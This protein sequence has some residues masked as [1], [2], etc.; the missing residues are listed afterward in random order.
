MQTVIGIDEAGRGPVLGPLVIGIVVWNQEA[1][2]GTVKISDSKKLTKRQ[3]DRARKFI[4]S[5]CQTTILAIPAWLISKSPLPLQIL[6][7][8][9]IEAAL[10]SFSENHTVYCDALGSGQT[11]HNLIKYAHPRRKFYFEPRA[12]DLYPA[13]AAASIM[14][15]TC[16]DQC[17][18]NIKKRW[19]DTGSGYPSDPKTKKWLET[20]NK[21]NTKW[22]AMVRTSWKTISNLKDS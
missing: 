16:R 6:E 14:A 17:M 18:E 11:A 13:V 20:H 8:Q 4:I 12:D 9:A 19:G 10:H 22:P 15:K 1:D 7:A 2:T 21:K 5:T 3:R